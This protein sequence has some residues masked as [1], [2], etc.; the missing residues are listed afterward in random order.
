[1]TTK[2]RHLSILSG[3]VYV[4]GVNPESGELRK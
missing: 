3:A 2:W 1:M 4:G